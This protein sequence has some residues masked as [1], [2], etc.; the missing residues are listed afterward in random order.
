LLDALLPIAPQLD[1]F[2][3]GLASLTDHAVEF[4]YPGESATKEVAKTA[5]ANCRVARKEIRKTLGM[6]EPP[7][8]QMNLRIKERRARYKVRRKKRG[9]N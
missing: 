3:K 2:R 1:T 6:D 9:R 4:R 7:S 8:G 5:F